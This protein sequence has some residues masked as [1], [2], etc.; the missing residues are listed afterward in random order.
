VENDGAAVWSGSSD[1]YGSD[2]AVFDNNGAFEARNSQRFGGSDVTFNNAGVFTK[3]L[4]SG[5]TTMSASFHNA[6]T[7][8][9]QSGILE[10]S[11]ADYVQ[12]GG[13]TRLNGGDI[14]VMYHEMDVQGGTLVGE[15]TVTGDV[16]NKGSVRP[17]S[18]PGIIAVDGDYTQAAAGSLEIE[19]GGT[20]AG[21]GFDQLAVSGDVTLAGTLDVTLDGFTPVHGDAFQIVTCDG[22][23]GTFQTLHLPTLPI[24]LFW[25]I[26]YTDQAVVLSVTEHVIF[27]PIVLSN[28]SSK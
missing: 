24:G 8:S 20:T 9:V 22:R 10:F 13:V 12:T 26:F 18:S 21:A 2:G 7:V 25:R 17:G 27:L 14:D 6:G 5:T 4:S 15:G 11:G 1:V 19:I 3:T 23:T 28:V 16:L